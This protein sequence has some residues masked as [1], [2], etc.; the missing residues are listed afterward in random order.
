VYTGGLRVQT[1]LDPAVQAAAEAAAAKARAGVG[2]VKLQPPHPQAGQADTPFEVAMASIEPPTGFVKAIV[3]GADFYA[4]GGQVNLALG[5]CYRPNV[6]V[7][8]EVEAT[9]WPLNEEDRYVKSGGTGRQPGSSFKPFVLAAA[10]EKGRPSTGSPTAGRPRTSTAPSATTKGA[11]AAARTS[12]S[13]PR[14]RT[15]R[16]TRSWC[17]TWAA[18]RPARWPRSSA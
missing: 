2:P 5:G 9:C 4:P 8:V 14:S 17:A 3:G 6:N 16:S 18:R 1:T 7:P 11:V 10:F 12:G 15:T 13:P